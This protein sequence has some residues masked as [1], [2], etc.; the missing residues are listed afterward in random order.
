MAEDEEAHLARHLRGLG[1]DACDVEAATG[2]EGAIVADHRFASLTA[3]PAYWREVA[4]REV[5][6]AYG[7]TSH[8]TQVWTGADYLDSLQGA[9]HPF[10]KEWRAVPI[11]TTPA[12]LL[13]AY[14][15][16]W[17]WS[18]TW[19]VSGQRGALRWP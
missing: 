11:Q 8:G 12:S 9:D 16:G 14:D 18:V 7:S 2:C 19:P 5:V 17:S 1:T 15:S 4:A 3:T 10:Q 6:W 13:M